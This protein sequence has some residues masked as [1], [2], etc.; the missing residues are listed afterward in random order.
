[1]IFAPKI[2]GTDDVDINVKAGTAT[3]SPGFI[4][5][6]KSAHNIADDPLFTATTSELGPPAGETR[7]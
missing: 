6:P 5:N 4:P 2:F 1:M 3:V 7:I